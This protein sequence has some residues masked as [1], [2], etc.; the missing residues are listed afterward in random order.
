MSRT[1]RSPEGGFTLIELLA[2]IIVGG[3]LLT[4]LTTFYLSEQRAFRQQQIQIE[5]SQAL[6]VALEQIVRDVR[7]AGRNPLSTV[8][9][10]LT[11]ASG[12]ELRFTLDADGDGT[13]NLT[14]RAEHK[15]FQLN[16]T[17]IRT[18]VADA[19]NPWQDLAAYVDPAATP[20]FRYYRGDLTEVTALPASSTDLS[21]IRRVD[22][23]LTVTNRVPAAPDI[24]RTEAAT[25]RLRNLS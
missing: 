1:S 20:I 22:V 17:V 18:W 13:A 12:T 6:R 3:V 24:N 5:T 11:Y 4:A 2:V 7:V 25:I 21:A 15:G 9:I 16:G 19:L 10:G 23:V 8:G 14:D